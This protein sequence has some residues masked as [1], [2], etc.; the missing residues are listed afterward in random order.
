MDFTGWP[1]GFFLVS[2]GGGLLALV[3]LLRRK[4]PDDPQRQYIAVL[5]LMAVIVLVLH[6]FIPYSGTTN[7]P[8]GA[9]PPR[10]ELRYLLIPF[11]IGIILA[12][13]LLDAKNRRRPLCWA[14]GALAIVTAFGY[15]ESLRPGLIRHYGAVSFALG[16]AALVSLNPVAWIWSRIRCRKTAAFIAVAVLL[17]AEVL[18]LPYHQRLTDARILDYLSPDGGANPTWTALEKLPPG[19]HHRSHFAPILSA[20]WA[21]LSVSGAARPCGRFAFP[22]TPRAVENGARLVAVGGV[23]RSAR[24]RAF[25]RQSP[26]DGRPVRCRGAAAGDSVSAGAVASAV[27]ATARVSPRTTHCGKRVLGVVPIEAKRPVISDRS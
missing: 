1:F 11:A 2:A 24:S 23:R 27:Q 13:P 5:S 25:R 17:V 18:M 7:S 26:Q 19:S 12:G 14:L 10:I 21:S 4:V 16:A 22:A 3:R 8:V 20:L 9:E 15:S 6:P